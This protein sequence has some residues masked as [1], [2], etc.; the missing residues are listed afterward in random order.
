MKKLNIVD[1]YKGVLLLNEFEKELKELEELRKQITNKGV[2]NEENVLKKSAIVIF[3][4][5]LFYLAFD[6]AFIL[7]LEAFFRYQKHF[8]NATLIVAPFIVLLIMYS[9]LRRKVNEYIL[10]KRKNREI[11]Y[12]E[13]N[14]EVVNENIATVKESL[15][16]YSTIPQKYHR[17]DLLEIAIGY[18]KTGKA[19]DEAHALIILEKEY[20]DFFA[21]SS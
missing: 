3:V 13:Q 5:S 6:V 19:L 8:I 15:K 7:H 17:K 9:R 18:M 20:P 1:T 2:F 12:Y 21:K 10:K 11:I 14:K 4:I 16:K